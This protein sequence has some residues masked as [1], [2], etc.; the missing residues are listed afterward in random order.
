MLDVWLPMVGVGKSLGDNVYLPVKY[1]SLRRKG[2]QFADRA[3][4]SERWTKTCGLF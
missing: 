4:C 2:L 1:E 3:A